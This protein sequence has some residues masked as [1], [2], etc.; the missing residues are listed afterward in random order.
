MNQ[1]I[2][3]AAVLGCIFGF[4]CVMH[5]AIQARNK[6]ESEPPYPEHS[7]LRIF[8]NQKQFMM[9]GI[10]KC[11]NQTSWIYWQHEV[12]KFLEQNEQFIDEVMYVQ[13]K[14]DLELL[15]KISEYAPNTEK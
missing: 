15:L 11:D 5:L 10:R 3:I 2:M 13:T 12:D 1:N 4:G 14:T 6:K 8:T 7:F 9:D